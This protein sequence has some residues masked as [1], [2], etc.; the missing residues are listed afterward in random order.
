MAFD[1]SVILT[2]TQ[3][4]FV[5]TTFTDTFSVG[6]SDVDM[7]RIELT[8]G[9]RYTFDVD[10]GTVGD[11]YLRVFNAFGT[12][13][14]AV[15]DGVRTDD[16]VLFALSPYLE[17][18]PD[19]GGTYFVAVSPYSLRSYDPFSTLGRVSPENP[20]S[21][22]EGTLTITSRG[23]NFFGAASSIDGIDSE[24]AFDH[25]DQLRETD[26]TLRVEMQGAIDNLT[27]VDMARVDLNKSDV[28]VVDVNGITG[29]GTV[30]TVIRIFNDSG[31]QIGFD[32]NFG[33]GEDPE[34][35]FVAPVLNDYY[36][37]ISGDGNASYSALDGT[38]TLAAN[39]TGTFEVI[40][41]LNPTIIGNSITNVF[42]GGGGT[43]TL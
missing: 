15:D 12:E 29:N 11:F 33:S 7:V 19:V 6:T 4:V 26:R 32:S 25:T 10:N 31:T 17:F 8:A 35:V 28:L 21:P 38:G 27:D 13:V 23:A 2:A 24:G 14:R 40:L 22:T 9:V 16:D 30:G 43:I 34:L 3:A 39:G 18:A 42:A 36:I 5:G 41:H 20:M 1:G 37:G